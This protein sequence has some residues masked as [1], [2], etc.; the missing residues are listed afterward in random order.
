[1]N[2]IVHVFVREG[3]GT[4]LEDLGVISVTPKP[5]RTAEVQFE[6]R[7]RPAVGTVTL[8][9]PNNWEKRLG[10]IPQV[11]VR[12]SDHRQPAIKVRVWRG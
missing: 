9:D 5:V 7:G 4:S 6:Y 11:H 10:V 8:I 3:R 1:M 2:F 12:L